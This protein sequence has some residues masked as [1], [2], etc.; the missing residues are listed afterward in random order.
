MVDLPR[1]SDE[2]SFFFA[3]HKSFGI[4]T[5]IVVFLRIAWR[6]SHRAPALPQSLATWQ[7]R[8]ATAVHHLLY[9]FLILQPVSGYVSSSF[10]GYKTRLWGVALPH[11]GWKDQVLNETFT[12]I[13][14]A[15]SVAL[16][17]LIGIHL[18][19][20][21]AHLLMPHENVLRRMV[22]W[23]GRERRTD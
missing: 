16:L 15:S 5:A 23:F 7:R 2:R 13:H 1:G 10:S 22:P 12:E 9:F 14:V 21:L 4:T 20:A 6:V 8:A 17:I 11:W 18:C 19:G 3:L